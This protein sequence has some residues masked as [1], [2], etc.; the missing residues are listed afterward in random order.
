[1]LVSDVKDVANAQ[2]WHLRHRKLA[3]S[4]AMGLAVVVYR[5]AQQLGLFLD[6]K[7]TFPLLVLGLWGMVL[8]LVITSAPARWL[9]SQYRCEWEREARTAGAVA[10]LL[11]LCIVAAITWFGFVEMRAWHA[12]V[13]ARLKGES[14]P[15]IAKTE[16]VNAPNASTNGTPVDTTPLVNPFSVIQGENRV[17]VEQNREMQLQ[18]AEALKR[19]AVLEGASRR[20][21]AVRAPGVAQPATP[22]PP[23]PPAAQAS[24]P[25]KPLPPV[26][27]NLSASTGTACSQLGAGS[28]PLSGNEAALL[29][30]FS[31]RHERFEELMRRLVAAAQGIIENPESQNNAVGFLNNWCSQLEADIEAAFGQL[32]QLDFRNTKPS[33]ALLTGEL[34][35]VTFSENAQTTI[36]RA[37]AYKSCLQAIETNLKARPRP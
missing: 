22:T 13:L 17:L 28:G 2:P 35:K 14:E 6:D 27:L 7:N 12:K 25:P 32:A 34:A 37:T 23:S 21:A 18:L 11:L 16:P 26:T 8:Y 4:G 15:T 19:I 3:L 29:G 20:G 9:S 5:A 1:M 31:E 36:R 10:G 30:K 24:L 33:D